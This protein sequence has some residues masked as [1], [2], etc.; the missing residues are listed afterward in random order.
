MVLRLGGEMEIKK[1]IIPI[2]GKGSRIAP[3]SNFIPKEMLPIVDKPLI[4]YCI[5]EAVEAGIH[6]F[7]LII[8]PSKNMV[9]KYIEDTFAN[10]GC[11]FTYVCQ[12][13]Q[14]GLGGAV[15]LA[16]HLIDKDEN[17]S[18]LLPDDLILDGSTLTEMVD[19][20]ESG[21][22]LS[23]NVVDKENAKKYGIL[24][25]I[26]DKGC[27]IVIADSIIEKPQN[28]VSDENFAVVG[29]YILPGKIMS[30]LSEVKPGVGGEIQLTDAIDRLAKNGEQLAGYKFSGKKIDCGNKCGW[31]EAILTVA[32]THEEIA[33]NGKFM[34]NL[35]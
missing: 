14:N 26:A 31:I 20:Y 8:N 24:H 15:L 17:F 10:S 12:N 27:E 1:A 16:S 18:I 35:I 4:H 5:E 6:E 30:I 2:A 11:K 33:K 25:A 23:V 28:V 21:I 29:R 32:R 19:K 9:V 13:V 34:E 7:I 22:L 3:I